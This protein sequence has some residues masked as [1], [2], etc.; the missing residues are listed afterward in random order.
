[1]ANP[2]TTAGSVVN[3]WPFHLDLDSPQSSWGVIA[4]AALPGFEDLRNGLHA[5]KSGLLNSDMLC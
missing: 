2:S 5:H 1:M 4:A 3:S